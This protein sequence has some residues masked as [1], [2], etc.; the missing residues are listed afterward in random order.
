[1]VRLLFVINVETDQTWIFGT[2]MNNIP[3]F[4][5]FKDCKD[6]CSVPWSKNGQQRAYKEDLFSPWLHGRF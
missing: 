4:K 5:G 3:V 2:F 1:M 6:L